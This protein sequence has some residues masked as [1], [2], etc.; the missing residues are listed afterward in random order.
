MRQYPDPVSSPILA[1]LRSIALQG[2]GG[3]GPFYDQGVLSVISQIDEKG[4]FTPSVVR[5]VADIHRR[6]TVAESCY[7]PQESAAA[8]RIIQEMGY[9]LEQGAEYADGIHTAEEHLS[10]FRQ[11]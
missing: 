5:I 3:K 1:Q 11:E 7:T 2:K 8:L 10:H 4:C 9:T 6:P